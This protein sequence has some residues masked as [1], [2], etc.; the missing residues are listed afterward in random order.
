MKKLWG[1]RFKKETAGEMEEFQNSL[2]FDAR[3]YRQDIRGSIAHARM[4]GR[5]GIIDLDEAEEIVSGLE[6]IGGEIEQGRLEFDTGAEDIHSF[7]EACLVERIGEAGK[8]LHSARSRNDQVATDLRLYLKDEIESLGN[9]LLRLIDTLARRAQEHKETIM[10]GYTHLQRAQPI[11]FAHH[12]LAYCEM[13]R[14]DYARLRDCYKRTD[15]CPLGAG[16]LAGTTF[17]IDRPYTA[18]K[19]GFRDIAANTLD[20]VSDRDFVAEFIFA[21]SLIMTHLSRFTEELILWSSSEFGFVVLDDA[22]TTGSSIMPQ[23]KNPDVPELVRGKTGRVYG[24]LTGILT[25]LKGLPLAYNKDL[26]EDKEAVFD[27][28]DTVRG[29]LGILIPL[30]QTLKA[31]EG[32]MRAAAG[33]DFTNATDLADY[34]VWHDVSFRDAHRIAG[35]AVLYC[36]EKGKRLEDLA[37]SEYR[38]IS[39]AFDSDVYEYISIEACVTRRDLPGGPAPAAVAVEIADLTSWLEDIRSFPWSQPVPEDEL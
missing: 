29:C 38:N 17:P 22:Y 25:V 32:R 36:I 14:R 20:A 9:L 2:T 39:P 19:L 5:Q 8:K 6:Q 4:L 23:K 1:G 37:F 10:P 30:V 34:L 15:I 31:N 12:L 11:T 18:R 28:I 13:L 7:I 26:Q 3:L 24:H 21:A 33:G 16:A 35:E 27:T